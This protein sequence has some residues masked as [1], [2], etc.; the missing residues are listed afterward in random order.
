MEKRERSAF[1][2][3]ATNSHNF[4][5]LKTFN[6]QSSNLQK[7]YF[8]NFQ[9]H[10]S[11]QN[12]LNPSILSSN[13]PNNNPQQKVLLKQLNPIVTVSNQLT[14]NSFS[15]K[16]PLD[17]GSSTRNT[18]S[19]RLYSQPKTQVPTIPICSP[20]I[21]LTKHLVLTYENLNKT[22]YAKL[23][24]KKKEA[25]IDDYSR[26]TTRKNKSIDT[27]FYSY[28]HDKRYK[29]STSNLLNH[30]CDDNTILNNNIQNCNPHLNSTVN[31]NNVNDLVGPCDDQNDDYIIRPGEVWGNRFTVIKIL[32]KG[33][34]GQV[35]EAH[36]RG[37]TE[38]VAIKIVKNRKSF[39]KQALNEIK[40]LE[41]LNLRDMDDSKFIVRMK[42]FFLHKNHACIVYEL[43]SQ[44][45]YE[46]LHAGNFKGVSLSLV[47]NFAFQLL[48]ALSF[49]NRK[50]VNVIHCDLKPENSC[51]YSEK[52]Y[53]NHLKNVGLM[54]NSGI[55]IPAVKI[56]GLPYSGAIDIWSLGCILIE[57]L[58]G[59]PLCN[60]RSEHDQMTKI[61][62]VLEKIPTKKMLDA[63]SQQ[64]VSKMFN[65]VAK[66]K[67]YNIS[68]YSEVCE[69]NITYDD[70]WEY[71]LVPNQG[72]T[73][74][75]RNVKS[76]IMKKYENSIVDERWSGNSLSDYF[77]F[78]DFVQLMLKLDPSERT[79]PEQA[80][81]HPFF[82]QSVDVGTNT[83]LITEFSTIVGCGGM[84]GNSPMNSKTSTTSRSYY[85]FLNIN[86]SNNEKSPS[87]LKGFDEGL[88]IGN[89]KVKHQS[90]SM[91]Y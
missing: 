77:K 16:G 28:S 84:V 57:L 22:Y 17:F 46:L 37:S 67:K 27:C 56:I 24:A 36:V 87:V 33:S 10:S 40:L 51:F 4:S 14:P 69:S 21:K 58:C 79:T 7:P 55:Y 42:G 85:E 72:Y 63:G 49:F 60:G 26:Q 90:T 43:L 91:M 45:L 9:N 74:S 32:G 54:R 41:H 5:P 64:K 73:P 66:R 47:R 30:T 71:E 6:S 65:K 50:D 83:D 38:K 82:R 86:K 1:K 23:I 19:R 44:N 39:F 80:L 48:T 29:L 8:N 2:K 75:R 52:V 68:S 89:V 31:T 62:D 35:V 18:L 76:I 11:S 59:E 25:D 88:F 70:E 13:L 15:T 78:L 34:F 81:T 20:L 3:V 61:C 53:I 12:S